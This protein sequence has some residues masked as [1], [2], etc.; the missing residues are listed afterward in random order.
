MTDTG[1]IMQRLAKAHDGALKGQADT[2]A[3]RE[4]F[5]LIVAGDVTPAVPRPARAGKARLVV[6]TALVTGAAAAAVVLGPGLLAGPDATVYANSAIELQR[7]GDQWLARIKDPYADHHRYTE[8]FAA[9]GLD[10]E[11]R[12][13]PSSPSGVGKLVGFG[14]AYSPGSPGAG[15]SLDM[16][17]DDCTGA[18]CWM[19]LRVPAD[20]AGRGEVQIGRE[21]RPGESYQNGASAASPGEVLEGVPVREGRTVAQ[22]LPEIRERKLTVTYSRVRTGAGPAGGSS[23]GESTGRSLSLEPISED[24]VGRDW[25]VWEAQPVKSGHV[26][27]LVTPDQVPKNPLYS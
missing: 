13:V 20:F 18:D 19:S 2:G 9:V 12:L 21:A 7:D 14:V 24:E 15:G 25:R 3:A 22:L 6:A 16:A 4:L 26:R 11:L 8:A 23:G 27:L 5:A 17:I 10:V 1:P